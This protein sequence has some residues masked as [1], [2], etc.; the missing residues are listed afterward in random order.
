MQIHRSTVGIPGSKA[1]MK[2]LH[3]KCLSFLN[4][5]RHFSNDQ[6]YFNLFLTLSA[7][8]SHWPEFFE[9]FPEGRAHLAKTVVDNVLNIPDGQDRS[10]YVTK[11]EDFLWRKQFLEENNRFFDIFFR[12]R[13]E[14]YV[15]EVLVK[16]LGALDYIIR[17]EFQG[18]GAIHAHL[19]LVLPMELGIDE[20]KLAFSK[21]TK[22]QEKW[23][24]AD[25]VSEVREKHGDIIPFFELDEL[26]VP[27]TLVGNIMKARLHVIRVVGDYLGLTECHP[28]DHRGHWFPEDGGSLMHTPSP[29]VIRQGFLARVHQG[30]E[31]VVNLI[32][33][34]M[35]HRC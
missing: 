30:L 22:A 25:V 9:L 24:Y 28:S 31:A 3:D 4:F 11:A 34:T 15:K 18:R 14:E 7:A 21:L 2:K 32:N 17:Y 12:I 16:T 19:L 33:L 10:S 13:V 35:I 26:F 5:H 20:R 6:T 27:S 1:Q 29:Q 8:D 23:A